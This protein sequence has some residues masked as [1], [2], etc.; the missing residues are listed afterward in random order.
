IAEKAE[1]VLEALKRRGIEEK[2]IQPKVVYGYFPVQAEGDDLV[3]Y[4][5][6]D[7]AAGSRAPR[8]TPRERA[9]FTFPRQTGRR[10]LCIAD[11]FRSKASGEFD[12]LGM[13][14]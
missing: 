10:R 14:L 12:V 13:Q 8:G 9:R 6:E 7:F 4:A 1:P 5:P 3:L 11:F 2:L